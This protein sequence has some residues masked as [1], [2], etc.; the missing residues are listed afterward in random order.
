MGEN[1][2]VIITGGGTGGHI[3]PAIAI[4]KGLQ[5]RLGQTEILYVGAKG[6]MEEELAHLEGYEFLGIDVA[7]LDRSSILRS[8]R[9]VVKS[10]FGY[11]QA[12]EI[13]KNYKPQLVIGTGGYVCGPVVLA[14]ALGNIPTVVHEQNAL[15]G[16]SIKILAR[17]VD[18]ICLTFEEAG[19]YLSYPG[20]IFVTGLPVRPK[21]LAA[22]KTT[23]QA[24]LGLVPDKKTVLIT[25]GSQGSRVINQAT[26]GIWQCLCVLDCQIIHITGPKLFEETLEEAKKQGLDQK[27]SLHIL[28]YLHEMQDALAAADIIVGRA[29]ASF[30]AEVMAVGR[31][32]ILVPYPYAA[33]NHQMYNALAMERLGAA[34]II[35]QKDLNSEKLLVAV[36][37]ILTDDRLQEKMAGAATLLGNKNALAD[38]VD[39]AVKTAVKKSGSRKA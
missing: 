21:F 35:A 24:R 39:V 3:Y 2:K 18:A 19:K 9:S 11:F 31:A 17:Y 26:A 33:G 36:K 28:P 22:E 15:P 4:A 12:R 5:N 20:K 34:E 23:A 10:C 8:A 13:I 30:L 27:E 14:A 1:V 7:G 16:L 29:G 25:G 37:K 6:G 32:S 38:I